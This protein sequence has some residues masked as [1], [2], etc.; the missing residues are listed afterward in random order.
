MRWPEADAL[1]ADVAVT[2]RIGGVSDGPYASLNLGF[3]V[4]DD[5]DRV[6]LNRTRAAEAFGVDLGS[7]VFAQQVHGVHHELVGPEHH[8]MG[9]S[10]LED[11]VPSTDILVTTSVSTTI[12]VLV[13]DCVPLALI[14]PDARVLAVVHA[15]WRG[16]AAGAVG[17]AV[18]AMAE[19]GAR[20]ERMWAFVGPAVHPSR[21]QVDA[22]VL[23]GLSAAVAPEALPSEVAVADG[24]GGW[25]VDLIAANRQQLLLA[26]V[27]AGRMT[28]SGASTA[29]AEFFSHRAARPCGRFALMA[30]LRD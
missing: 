29:D 7:M 27:A 2:T 3:H 25:L 4:G 9:T 15:G 6:R 22:D 1:R 8:G 30:R 20:P 11:A 10:T 13:A 5:P 18:R 16:T 19:C 17:H 23:S 12:V 28:I 14:D 21:Y 26:G 24:T